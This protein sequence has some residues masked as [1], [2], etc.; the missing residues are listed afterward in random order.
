VGV[1]PQNFRRTADEKKLE[2]RKNDRKE[3]TYVVF[4]FD[5]LVDSPDFSPPETRL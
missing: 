2:G 1:G 3:M 5:K 4:T